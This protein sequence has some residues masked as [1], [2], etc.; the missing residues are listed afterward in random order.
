MGMSFMPQQVEQAIP[1]FEKAFALARES[2]N[3]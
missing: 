3:N 1:Y 2:Q